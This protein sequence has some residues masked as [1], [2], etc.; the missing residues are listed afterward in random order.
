MN[1][2]LCP[3]KA[4]SAAW[5][6]NPVMTNSQLINHL[7]SVGYDIIGCWL[8]CTHITSRAIKIMRCI[9]ILLKNT[10]SLFAC[11]LVR[12]N[13]LQRLNT[14][15]MRS[16]ISP[17]M[18]KQPRAEL[19]A[20]AHSLH[21]TSGNQNQNRRLNTISLP[22]GLLSSSRHQSKEQF[23]ALIRLT[24]QWVMVEEK[25]KKTRP[26][27]SMDDRIERKRTNKTTQRERREESD[28]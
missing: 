21:S 27:D 23:E 20:S 4:Y 1:P 2:C 8:L 25:K 6:V 5:S 15:L 3:A 11:E 17:W 19:L 18:H 26:R 12:L 22:S 14:T 24:L 13:H 16:N 7:K 28:R 10:R 9:Q